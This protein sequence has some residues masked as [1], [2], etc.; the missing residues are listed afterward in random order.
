MQGQK[1]QNKRGLGNDLE[2][3]K[4][5]YGSPRWTGEIADCSLPMTLDTYSNCSFGCVYCFSQ[6]QRGIG[7]T[8]DSYFAKDVKCVN[9]DKI[10][11]IFN[12]ENQKVSSGLM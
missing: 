8:K 2:T 10:K 5:N 9:V 12:G 1:N 6:Y 7:N 3:I 4:N 11:K